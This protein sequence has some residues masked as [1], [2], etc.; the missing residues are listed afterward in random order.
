[1]SESAATTSGGR[2][3]ADG[4]IDLRLLQNRVAAAARANGL[5]DVTDLAPIS[6]HGASLTYRARLRDPAGI[7]DIVIKVAPPGLEPVRNRDV[8]RQARGIRAASSIPGVLVP[9]VLLE[10]PGDPP[11]TPPLFVMTMVPGDCTEP[12]F[13]GGPL[14]S[15]DEVRGRALSAARIL[16]AL[17]RADPRSVGLD[18]QPGSLVSEVE[19]WLRA[20]MTVSEEMRGRA[21]DAARLLLGSVPAGHPPAFIHGDYRLGNT[22]CVGAEVTA[23]I[24][25]EIW[26]VSDPRIDLAWL[27]LHRDPSSN[28]NASREAPGMP[29]AAE[30]IEE[31]QRSAGNDVKDLNW[32]EALVRFKQAAIGALIW[33]RAPAPGGEPEVLRRRHIVNTEVLDAINLL[34]ESS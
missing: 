16:G 21:E 17:H 10:D 7:S 28:P 24:D 18:E 5:G 4:P 6:V 27:L 1:M 2:P 15:P 34:Q 3:G 26:S 33:K 13:G 32:F 12:I 23:V 9:R 29:T 8:L 11:A 30:I 14:L 22:L 20:F 25:W 19:R 31:Y